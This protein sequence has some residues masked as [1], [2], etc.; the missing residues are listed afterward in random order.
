MLLIS[1]FIL[2]PKNLIELMAGK[3]SGGAMPQM[4]TVCESHR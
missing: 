3:A 2:P 4:L 1:S